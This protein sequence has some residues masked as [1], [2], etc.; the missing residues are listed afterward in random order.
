MNYVI[1]I[2][3]LSLSAIFSGLTLGLFSLNVSELKRKIRLGDKK[4]EK[5]YKVRKNGNLLLC[6]LLIGNVAVNSTMAIFLG[7]IATG[8]VAGL[9]ST[10]LILVFG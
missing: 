7:S 3:L 9:I 2:L 1:I 8:V 6:T 10:G 5:V 4:A